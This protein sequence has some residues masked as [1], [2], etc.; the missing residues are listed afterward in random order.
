M[1]L[2]QWHLRVTLESSA[3]KDA[4]EKAKA[5]RRTPSAYVSVLI[6][7]DLKEKPNDPR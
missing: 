1:T 3:K 4:V 2:E 6:E 7:E 5:Q